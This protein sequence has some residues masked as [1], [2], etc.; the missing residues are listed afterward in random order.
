MNPMELHLL[1]SNF[2]HHSVSGS[3]VELGLFCFVLISVHPC[4]SVVQMNCFGLGQNDTVAVL[5]AFNDFR[6]LSVRDPDLYRNLA[7]A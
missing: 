2:V 3:E 7:P 5:K 6:A 4:P 1:W